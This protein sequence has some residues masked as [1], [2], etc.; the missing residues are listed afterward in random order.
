M[1]NG[2]Q[3]LPINNKTDNFL[4][5]IFLKVGIFFVL[6]L[7]HIKMIRIRNTADEQNQL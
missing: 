4:R 2:H 5:N 1:F 7:I 3:Y 6:G